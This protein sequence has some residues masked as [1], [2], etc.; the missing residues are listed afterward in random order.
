ML[1]GPSPFVICNVN[2]GPPVIMTALFI[3][4]FP[5]MVGYSSIVTMSGMKEEASA[6]GGGHTLQGLT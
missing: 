4:S 5:P 3:A 6:K 1:M 2:R